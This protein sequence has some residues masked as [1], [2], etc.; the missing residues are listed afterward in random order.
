M[1]QEATGTLVGR[2]KLVVQL[3][4]STMLKLFEYH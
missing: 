2:N 3:G 1:Q 4:D